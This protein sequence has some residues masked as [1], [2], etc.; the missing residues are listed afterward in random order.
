MSARRAAPRSNGRLPVVRAVERAARIIAALWLAPEGK[1]LNDLSEELGLHKTT[2]LRLLRTL[3]AIGAVRRDES[4]D[5][6]F[7]TPAALFG[8]PRAQPGTA[9]RAETVQ[10]ILDEAAESIGHPV[11]LSTPDPDRRRIIVV[12]GL[13]QPQANERPVPPD[14]LAQ[15]MHASACGKVY[16]ASL[17][18]AEVQQWMKGGL[19]PVTER[20]ITSPRRLMEELEQVRQDGF[21]VA[22]HEC[23]TGLCA[24][25]VPV[26]GTEGKMVGSLAVFEL[27]QGAINISTGRAARILRRAADRISILLRAARRPAR[28]M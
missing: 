25:A 19:P 8:I 4:T 15:P 6:Y 22:E 24:V 13:G 7:C 20:T 23:M 12:T 5:C 14:L 9:P 11:V 26:R 17:S 3:I 28:P 16:L 27:C 21:A 2:V 10:A 18:R 1:R